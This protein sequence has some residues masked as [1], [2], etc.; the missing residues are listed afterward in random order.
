MRR[1]RA[2]SLAHQRVSPQHFAFELT[3]QPATDVRVRR[4]HFSC[5]PTNTTECVHFATEV[6]FCVAF[7]AFAWDTVRLPLDIRI[8]SLLVV[9][10]LREK[11]CPLCQTRITHFSRSWNAHKN[12]EYEYFLPALDLF[13]RAARLSAYQC[14]PLEDQ[15]FFLPCIFSA[16]AACRLATL[17][18]LRSKTV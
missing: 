17:S 11:R 5:G 10:L 14:M 13:L 2:S 18:V 16:S 9:C 4:L 6:D 7:C 3:S 12:D 8:R 15:S 1:V